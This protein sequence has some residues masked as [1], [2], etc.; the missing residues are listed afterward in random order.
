MSV[1]RN[2]AAGRHCYTVRLDDFTSVP[3][4]QQQSGRRRDDTSLVPTRLPLGPA[5]MRAPQRRQLGRSQACPSPDLTTVFLASGT[6][7]VQKTASRKLLPSRCVH[8]EILDRNNEQGLGKEASGFSLMWYDGESQFL[9]SYQFRLGHSTVNNIILETKVEWQSIIEGFSEKW[10]FPNCCGAVYGKHM[11]IVKPKKSGSLYYNYKKIFSIVLLAV[12][13]SNCQ[14]LYVDVDAPSSEGD[15]R[16]WHTTPLQKAVEEKK[17]EL[18][19]L[20]KVGLS[21]GID[22]P[23]VFV[24]DDEFPL[25]DA[26]MKP[27]AG[28]HLPLNRRIFNYGLSRACRVVEN[29]F[30]ILANCFPFLHTLVDAELHRVATFVSA[31]C[32]LHNFLGLDDGAGTTEQS[33][34]SVL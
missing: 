31:A 26:M 5:L 20:V 14:F 27:Y 18:P 12:V 34:K 13:D 8:S 6:D 22:L 15:G 3:I 17:A 25:P 7:D 33:S 11:C 9:L 1:H 28:H 4:S 23:A 19:A 21:P 29:A 16:V 24:G 10:Q 32:A 30:G 2:T